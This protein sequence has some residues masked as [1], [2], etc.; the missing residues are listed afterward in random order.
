VQGSGQ[1]EA[2]I[3]RLVGELARLPGIGQRTASRLAYFLLTRSCAAIS[4]QGATRQ[5][6]DL[7]QALVDA[8]RGIRL[9]V[10]CANLAVAEQC[11]IC[12]DPRRD[13]GLLCVVE[14]IAELRAFEASGGYRGIYYVLHG[15]LN[16]LEGVGPDDLNM[17]HLCSRLRDVEEVV[18]ALNADV[19]GDTTALYIAKMLR[20][21]EVRVSRLA[22]GIPMGGE[23]EYMD[24]GTLARALTERRVLH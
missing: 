9:C 7:A 6:E 20:D 11:R 15:V 13:R 19:E 24:A 4:P 12:A 8:S 3:E 22:T 14:G 16:P 5:A 1:G 2:L 21:H 17:T 23:L 18:L 10:T